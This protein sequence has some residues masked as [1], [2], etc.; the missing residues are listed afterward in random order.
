MSDVLSDV[1]VHA[2]CADLLAHERDGVDPGGAAVLL[3]HGGDDVG[4]D[5]GEDERGVVSEEQLA[6]FDGLHRDGT[7]AVHT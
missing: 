2:L 4:V 1:A 7:A 6:L 5:L 3:L